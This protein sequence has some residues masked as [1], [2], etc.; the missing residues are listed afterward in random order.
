M[1]SEMEMVSQS[2]L[3]GKHLRNIFSKHFWEREKERETKKLHNCWT[4]PISLTHSLFTCEQGTSLPYKPWVTPWII[5]EAEPKI[6]QHKSL[7]HIQLWWT[8]ESHLLCDDPLGQK[9]I[10]AG[11]TWAPGPIFG[12]C[13]LDKGRGDLSLDCAH[14]VCINGAGRGLTHFRYFFNTGAIFLPRGDRRLGSVV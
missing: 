7:N 3:A 1:G 5:L 2:S 14:L 4:H 10:C 13:G 6:L 11:P 8:K 12:Q 9:A